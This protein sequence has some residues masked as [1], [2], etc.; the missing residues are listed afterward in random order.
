MSVYLT[1]PW[2]VAFLGKG[3]KGLHEITYP[4]VRIIFF[5]FRIQ[6]IQDYLLKFF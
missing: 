2:C 3:L 1:C 4:S 5:L 6:M